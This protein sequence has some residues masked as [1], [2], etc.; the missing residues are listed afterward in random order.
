V[1]LT[2]QPRTEA[3]V[4]ARDQIDQHEGPRRVVL[5]DDEVRE[6]VVVALIDTGLSMRAFSSRRSFW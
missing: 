6:L 3:G 4:P 1:L 2:R 5:L